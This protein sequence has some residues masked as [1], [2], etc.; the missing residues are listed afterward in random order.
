MSDEMI[1]IGFEV[2]TGGAVSVPRR[3]TVV[4]GQ[5][6]EAGK[7]TL[8]EAMV[9]RSGLSA[10]AFVTKRGESS[11][12]NAHIIDPYFREQADWQFVASILEASRGEK[13]RFE[14]AWIIRASKGAKTLADV[15]RNV[16]AA[17]ENAKGMSADV[18]LTLDA[19]LDAVVP[20]IAEVRW[21]Q[22]VDLRPGVNVMDLTRLNL[23]MQH[24]VIKSSIDWVLEHA[25]HTAVVVPEAWKFIPQG[26][27]TPVKRAAES[28]IRQSAGL[29][30]YLW[31]DS[32]DIAGVEKII[33]KSVPLW[34]LGVQRETNEI[35]KTIAQI[36]D[37]I[38]QKPRPAEIATLQLG[39]FFVC[40]GKTVRKVYAQPTWMDEAEAIRI[41]VSDA[42][43][44]RQPKPTP[45]AVQPVQ[46]ERINDMP[47]NEE[48]NSKLDTLIGLMQAN[49]RQ[50]TPAQ[51]QPA[52]AGAPADCDGISIDQLYNQFKTRLQQDAPALIRLMVSKPEIKV[53]IERPELRLTAG[54]L[55]GKIGALIVG[56]FFNQPRPNEDIHKELKRRGI[57]YDNRTFSR[58]MSDLAAAGALT[59]EAEGYKRNPEAT[60]TGVNVGK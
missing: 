14:R 26:R 54:R 59:I 35:K 29:Q 43:P 15:Q 57:S 46:E 55:D 12:T 47:T 40:Y 13:L 21:A 28:Y 42:A 8:L 37:S 19:Y 39:Q 11:F 3:H 9:A 45:P 20:Q 44:P 4:T 51:S 7:T 52:M 2:G 18:Y 56:G 30:N 25:R 38:Q 24:L 6:Q 10:L 16:Q 50:Q 31:L 23:E 53:E 17:M 27:G 32:Q 34:I 5:T 58:A 33:L 22:S 48:L 36:P 60:I 1:H 41:A 49:A